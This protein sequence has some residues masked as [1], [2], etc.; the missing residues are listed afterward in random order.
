[1]LKKILG[2]FVAVLGCVS[3]LYAN[4]TYVIDT[5]TTGILSYGSYS[6]DFWC[7]SYGNVISEIN[8]GVFKPLDL[9]VSWELDKFI[10]D[11]NIKA[12]VPALHVKL[13]LYGGSM[14]L[15]G[16]AFG[17]DGQGIFING[18][19]NGGYMQRCKGMYFVT[20]REFFIEGLMF[21]LGINMNDFSKPKIYWFSNATVPL[22]KE[23]VSFMLE[24][25]NVN[26]FPD[27]RL[28]CGLKFS[29]TE[30]LDIDCILRDCWGKKDV[31]GVPNERT[32]KI[33]Y[34]GK[35]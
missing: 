35:F 28:N 11:E 13:R 18:D 15:P 1:M 14:T 16:F 3:F 12:V 20:G 24:Y 27:A 2:A 6:A 32:L 34:L 17:Y 21:N 23:F 31:G 9:G 30:Y 26:Y 4:K 22:Y 7:F 33:S 29:V 25:D 19:Y 5:P 8:F 10:G